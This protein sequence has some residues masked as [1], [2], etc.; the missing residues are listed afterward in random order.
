[1]KIR[2]MLLFFS[3]FFSVI[4]IHIVFSINRNYACYPNKENMFKLFVI[5]VIHFPLSI[6]M[7]ILTLYNNC[8]VIITTY[9]LDSD[10]LSLHIIGQKN[11][12]LLTWILKLIAN[13]VND[14][15]SLFNGKYD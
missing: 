3:I 13:M 8:C 2:K 6:Q 15:I 5:A 4:S 9:M 10:H 7:N 14:S 11:L 1:M 12:L